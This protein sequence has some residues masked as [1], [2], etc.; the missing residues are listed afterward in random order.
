[1]KQPILFF[2]V[3]M[4]FLSFSANAQMMRM[5]PKER[6]EELKEKL[7]LDEEQTVKVE[8]IYAKADNEIKQI[9]QDGS[10]NRDQIRETIESIMSNSDIDIIKILNNEQKIKY[11]Q[12]IKEQKNR[13]PGKPMEPN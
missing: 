7:G 4:L 8:E 13:M 10:I 3:M 9:I 11:K 1:M 2:I 6:A 12:I 5:D